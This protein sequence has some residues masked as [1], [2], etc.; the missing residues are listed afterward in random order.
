MLPAKKELRKS[1][2]I[3]KGLPKAVL[4]YFKRNDAKDIAII[5]KVISVERKR[6]FCLLYYS[7]SQLEYVSFC[8]RAFECITLKV[9]TPVT[10]YK[11]APLSLPAFKLHYT[12]NSYS[13]PLRYE[14]IGDNGFH[15][16][17]DITD[18]AVTP[19]K[20]IDKNVALV[21][22][23]LKC[24]RTAENALRRHNEFNSQYKELSKGV[25]NFGKNLHNYAVF[26]VSDRYNGHCTEC[27]EDF[28][29]TQ[30]LKNNGVVKCPKCG[31]TLICKTRKKISR[32]YE[33]G[34]QCID[35]MKNG[36]LCVRHIICQKTFDNS[37]S[38]AKFSY[39]EYERD[40]FVNNKEYVFT[41]NIC[42]YKGSY[43][44]HRKPYMGTM[45]SM[46][47]ICY[48]DEVLYR[49]N[50]KQILKG[51]LYENSAIEY[52]P[53][54]TAFRAE[55]YLHR[56]TGVPRIEILVKAGYY[57]LVLNSDGN[58]IAK[59]CLGGTNPAQILGMNKVYREYAKQHN[60]ACSDVKFLSLCYENKISLQTQ[61]EIRDY[62]YTHNIY[63][64]NMVSERREFIEICKKTRA[65]HHKA[66]RYLSKENRTFNLWADYCKNYGALI[67]DNWNENSTFPI[68]LK[69]AHDEAYEVYQTR[70]N[71]LINRDV[72]KFYE[73]LES[74]HLNNVINGEYSCVL[75][76]CQ[77]DFIREGNS[78]N[79]CV[80]GYGY[81]EKYAQQ[82]AII[83]FVR[84]SKKINSSFCCCEARI[85]DNN[86]LYLAQCQ[87]SHH[88]EP[89]EDVRKVA[90]EYVNCLNQ[91]LMCSNKKIS[92]NQLYVNKVA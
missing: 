66:L 19:L 79:I 44:K 25:I 15:S 47:E 58:S 10:W 14:L 33:Y 27:N 75:P 20:Y 17:Y 70:K 64:H 31:K 34:I 57:S 1:V 24:K 35:K 12:G 86:E 7:K 53:E 11:S 4:S 61:E 48:A 76:T 5:T 42:R 32:F 89:T 45:F 91:K 28:T 2:D 71:E 23:V 87:L 54:E 73:K 59:L 6:L 65:N 69:K 18:K 13:S 50:L 80:G 67:E 63:Y 21:K 62:F 84:V 49:K 40:N 41:Y 38:C 88:R 82:K 55:D 30:K 36:T 46:R 85:N 78:L 83:F 43:W 60:Y 39:Y 52:I 26:D 16:Y 56:Y 90:E 8:N 9:P 22:E 37:F 92:I 3:M 72:K 51:T 81:A 74:V 77:D 68:N 29:V